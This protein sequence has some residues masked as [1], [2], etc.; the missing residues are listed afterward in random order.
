MTKTIVLRV[1]SQIDKKIQR[2]RCAVIS[3][4]P[5]NGFVHQEDAG[6]HAQGPHKGKVLC[7]PSRD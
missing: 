6:L 1:S 4:S 2:M 7:H 3:S 5:E